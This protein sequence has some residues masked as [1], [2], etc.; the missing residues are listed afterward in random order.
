MWRHSSLH[1]VEL[2]QG[3]Y[4]KHEFARHFHTVPA[5]GVV[6]RGTMRTYWQRGD[7]RLQTGSVLLLNPGEVHAPGPTGEDGWSFRMFY[8]ANPVFQQLS[9][10]V[11]N[12][13]IQFPTPFVQDPL[14]ARALLHLHRML[15]APT[16]ALEADT[17]LLAVFAQLAQNHA[18]AS[19]Q[20]ARTR[21][22]RNAVTH[23]REYLQAS[24]AENVS[25]AELADVARV[26]QYHL[27]RAF[28]REVGLPPHS[29]LIQLRIE[30]AQ[31]LLRAGT[32]ISDVAA[33]V[34][35]ADQS[36]LTRHFK[37]WTGVTP[38]QYRTRAA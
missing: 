9:H 3:I 14:L 26:T 2:F 20:P 22:E 4:R 11:S 15:E 10:K 34:G 6:D 38:N 17:A 33:L 28:R 31:R 8:F 35:F 30:E 13:L 23:A 12:K 25:L 7:H 37:R 21:T 29:Y 36:H 27:V 19:K 24:Y 1:G 32:A 18:S 16:S 5:I